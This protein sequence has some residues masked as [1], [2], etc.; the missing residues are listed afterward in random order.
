MTILSKYRLVSHEGKEE[1]RF[2]VNLNEKNRLKVE[3]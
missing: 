3:G 2:D 1:M